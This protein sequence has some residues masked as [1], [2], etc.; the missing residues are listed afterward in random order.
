MHDNPERERADEGD[1]IAHTSRGASTSTAAHVHRW[2][3]IALQVIMA[4]EFVA[5]LLE[6]QWMAAVTVARIM[7]ITAAPVLFRHPLPVN[8]PPEFL[9]W[10]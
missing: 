10:P 4:V 7:A 6:G 5:V 1:D 8:I 9:L 3:V 2:V